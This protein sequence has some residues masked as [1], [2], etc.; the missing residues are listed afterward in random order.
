MR[1]LIALT[2]IQLTFLAACGGGG[3]VSGGGGGPPPPSQNIAPPGPPNVETITVDSG[4]NGVS[5]VNTAYVSVQVCAPGS[6][7]LC[8][9]IDHIE[10]DTGSTGLR[11]LAGA[12]NGTTLSLSQLPQETDGTAGTVLTECLPFVDGSSY[13]SLRLVDITL[14]VSMK[15]ASNVVV[16]V[17][18]DPAY[19]VPDGSVTGQS[20]CPPPAENTVTAFGA[21]GILG[22]GPFAQDCGSL[23]AT[24]GVAGTYYSCTST[25]TCA[26]STA[27]IMQQLQNPATLFTSDNNG[28]IV[29]LPPVGAAG[30][31]TVTGSLVFGIGTQSNNALGSAVVLQE[32]AF[33]G[34]ITATYKGTAY[35]KGFIDSGSNGNFFTDSSLTQCTTDM[36]FYCPASSVSESATLQ[37]TTGTMLS[38]DFSVAN[39]EVL[40][41]NLSYTAFNNVGG[42]NPTMQA[43]DLG[44]PFFFGR[45]MFTAIENASAGGYM[46][47]YFAY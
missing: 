27:G 25:T 23:C 37:G 9:T 10:V 43:F 19:P 15:T 8:Q 42:T 36:G 32:D 33:T 4:P 39:A 30:A 3:Y 18:G 28:V 12:I 31:A 47:P 46:G 44:L 17:I 6:T 26:D 20:A 45:N 16:Q 21:N 22:V 11:I 14:P 1:K 35:P 41:S 7:T 34:E 5:A 2:L 38:A 24:T 40:F 29:E 13:G